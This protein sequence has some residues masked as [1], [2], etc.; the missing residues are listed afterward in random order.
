MMSI[1]R[2]FPASSSATNVNSP[3]ATTVLTLAVALPRDRFG[4]QTQRGAALVQQ[5]DIDAE[6]VADRHRA[7]ELDRVPPRRE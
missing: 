2:G 5:V 1:S 3:S 4:F 7:G 6:L